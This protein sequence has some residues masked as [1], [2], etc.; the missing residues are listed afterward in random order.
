MMN[1]QYSREHFRYLLRVARRHL[2]NDRVYRIQKFKKDFGYTP[3]LSSPTTFNEKILYRMINPVSEGLFTQLA[4][5]LKAREYVGSLNHDILSI[6]YGVYQNVEQIDLSSLPERFVLKCNHDTG[7]FVICHDKNSFDLAKAKAKLS[8][9]LKQNMYYKTREWQ[10]KN[11]TPL[12]FCEEYIDRHCAAYNGIMPDVFRFHCFDS[13]VKYV[14]VEYTDTDNKQYTN[15]YD[16]TWNFQDVRLNGRDNA[17]T[18][19]PKPECFDEAIL[20]AESLS[21]ELDYCRVDLYLTS[22]KIYFSEFTFAPRNGRE[23][24]SPTEWD[25]VFGKNWNLSN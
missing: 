8:M 12:I 22:Q 2:R 19:I 24:F 7:S 23:R 20:I 11:I 17:P 16:N 14:E 4:D 25:A 3:N 18:A 21:H 13:V 10:Y 5:K 9:H 1:W 6:I 15:I